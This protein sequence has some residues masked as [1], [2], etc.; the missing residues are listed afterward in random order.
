MTTNWKNINWRFV[1]VK[2]FEK[3]CKIYE[4]SRANKMDL[5]HKLQDELIDSYEA[6][7]LAVRRVTMDS[8]GK[9]TAG[10]DGKLVLTYEQRMKLVDSLQLT[11]KAQPVK[12]IWIP[13][14]GSDEKRP[15]GIPTIEDR[16]AQALVLLALEPEWEAKF[17]EHSYGFRP[18]RKCHDAIK[19]I[20]NSLLHGSKW[21]YDADVE[22]CFDRINHHYLLGK[23][24]QGP[25][26]LIYRQVQA[27]LKAGILE[28]GCPFTPTD[29]GTP[30]GGVISP[31]LANVALHGLEGK[32]MEALKEEKSTIK[33]REQTKVIRYADDFL[34][35]TPERKWM[36]VAI[37][38]TDKHLAEIGLNIKKAKTRLLHSLDKDLCPDKDTSFKFLGF[39]IQQLPVGKRNPR[40][41]GNNRKVYWK[42]IIIPHPNK[43]SLHFDQI[44][45]VIKKCTKPS[46]VVRRLNPVIRGWTNYFRVSDAATVKQVAWYNKRLF[47]LVSNWQKRIYHTRK[48]LDNLWKTVGTNK[49]RFYAKSNGKEFILL[50]Y[51]VVAWSVNT[52]TKVNGDA[53]PYDG[54]HEYWLKRTSTKDPRVFAYLMKKQ[55]GHCPICGEIM[56]ATDKVQVDHII[57]RAKGGSEKTN[58]QQ[59]VHKECHAIKTAQERKTIKK[60]SKT[61]K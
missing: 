5:V 47:I 53:S 38:A 21:I 30:Q 37:K 54:N 10:V 58:N 2:I 52:Y 51:Q 56:L 32:I 61:K 60:V 40:R 44:R 57:P 49:W 9:K 14:P 18:G 29:M 48:P 22:K 28:K 39:K 25:N 41:A 17:E 20:K 8:T 43:V 26:S 36:E 34:I 13:K 6:K 24:S 11:G 12:R 31:L 16:A 19:Q 59:V 46:E 33:T 55:Q 42:V 3:Q 23:L 4:L 50:N 45:S 1:H 35:M 15:L 7:L 27:W